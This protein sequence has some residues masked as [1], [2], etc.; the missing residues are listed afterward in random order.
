MLGRAVLFVVLF[1][2][3]P[4]AILPFP[5]VRAGGAWPPPTPGYLHLSPIEGSKQVMQAQSSIEFLTNGSSQRSYLGFG[6][7]GIK[8]AIIDS[9][10]DVQN[11]VYFQRYY[12]SLANNSTGNLRLLS[13][14][15]A[16]G[17]CDYNATYA[18]DDTLGHGTLV[19]AN[20]LSIAPNATFYLIKFTNSD[21]NQ[22]KI[23][24]DCLANQIRPDVTSL[25][26]AWEECLSLLTP[27]PTSYD[28][29]GNCLCG[30]APYHCLGIGSPY[31]EI[32]ADINSLTITQGKTVVVAAGNCCGCG[33]F[34]TNFPHCWPASVPSVIAVGGSFW[35]GTGARCTNIQSSSNCKASDYA[36]SFDSIVYPGR[37]VPDLTGLVGLKPNGVYIE[38]PTQPNSETDRDFSIRAGDGTAPDDGWIVTSGTSS[39]APQVAGLAAI[40]RQAMGLDAWYDKVR[41][42]IGNT[43]FDI[44]TGTSANGGSTGPGFDAAT[45]YGLI[46]VYPAL[47]QLYASSLNLVSGEE[48][49]GSYLLTSVSRDTYDVLGTL[50]PPRGCP[51]SPG[52]LLT[53]VQPV[54]GRYTFSKGTIPLS[55]ITSL[56][57]QLEARTSGATA[58][59]YIYQYSTNSWISL[60]EYSEATDTVKT[61]TL[62]SPSSYISSQGTLLL[63]WYM[64]SNFQDYV[65]IDRQTIT[66]NVSG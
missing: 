22:V 30:N 43:A 61:V 51:L 46:D 54:D 8:V 6:G 3:S 26:Y 24:F 15:L 13:V 4:M 44:I 33:S 32:E 35:N 47:R 62:T 56:T 49:G 53:G 16:R 60:L 34:T 31:K 12:P 17:T 20:L 18:N 48:S 50:C 25:S 45:G 11:H 37:H 19:L 21:Q 42:L 66:I 40:I 52:L 36:E 58:T 65:Y 1:L 2:L 9:G 14:N 10:F 38:L 39:A 59:V 29:N 27:T 63:R 57:L 7:Q 23:A 41:D 55:S 28:S 5:S 64:P